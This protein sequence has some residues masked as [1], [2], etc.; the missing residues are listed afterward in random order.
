MVAGKRIVEID[1]PKTAKILMVVRGKDYITPVG[2]TVLQ[3]EDKLL[4]L[5][6]DARSFL[7]AERSLGV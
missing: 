6:E 3:G 4:I 7:A 2:S 5:A 1:F